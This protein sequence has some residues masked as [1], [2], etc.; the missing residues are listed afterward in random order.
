MSSPTSH[1]RWTKRPTE[2]P[3]TSD[4]EPPRQPGW[5]RPVRRL[6]TTV[7]VA[8]R[9]LD[10]TSGLVLVGVR[11]GDLE[12]V[13]FDVAGG[14]RRILVVGPRRSGR[15][16]TLHTVAAAL[17]AQGHPV[18]LVTGYGDADRDRLVAD[19]RAHPDLAVVVDDAERLAG[20]PVEAVLLEIARR[21]DEDQGVVVAATSTL[22]LESRT[23]ALATELA[24]ARTGV[25]LGPTTGVA[26]LGIGPDTGGSRSRTPGRGVLVTPSGTH[27]IHVATLSDLRSTPGFPDRP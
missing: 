27:R 21:V 8:S 13:G 18:A 5:P 20:T 15:S 2:A 1:D 24:R 4:G 9:E 23:S 19:R 10:G 14:D 3:A 6:P 7:H 12:R 17:G 22:A 26:S 16:T 11:D 25:V